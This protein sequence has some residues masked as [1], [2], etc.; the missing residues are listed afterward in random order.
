VLVKDPVIRR[1]NIASRGLIVQWMIES[2]IVPERAA[3]V[4]AIFSV[5]VQEPQKHHLRLVIA[6][7]LVYELL[8]VVHEQIELQIVLELVL[9]LQ[10]HDLLDSL[11][12]E[13]S[14]CEPDQDDPKDYHND[15]PLI[16]QGLQG[17]YEDAISKEPAIFQDACSLSST[18]GRVVVG[19]FEDKVVEKD[20]ADD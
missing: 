4:S 18:D 16:V 9:M 20:Q 2:V 17:L 7:L 13:V 5:H 6:L 11:V 8:E 10:N 15:L 19:Y 12:S 3:L 1:V 14:R